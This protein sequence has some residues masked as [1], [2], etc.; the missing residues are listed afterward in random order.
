MHIK[1]VLDHGYVRLVDT[2]GS[3]LTPVNAARVSYDKEST[4][5]TEKDERLL[6][7]LVNAG[8]Q[9]PF[10]HAVLQFEV[11]APLMVAR[12]WFKYRIGST[13]SEDSG[14]VLG[15][16]YN[17]GDDGSEDPLQARNESSRRYVTEEP[18]FYK[19]SAELW[20]TSPENKK[21][22]SGGLYQELTGDET[23]ATMA[24]NALHELITKGVQAYDKAREMGICA[25]QARLFLPAYAMYVRWYWTA[26]LQSVAHFL[27]QR[28]EH[29]AQ[30]EIQQY[31]RAVYELTKPCFPVAMSHFIKGV[32]NEGGTIS[33]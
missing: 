7:F 11:Y 5:L 29:D 20:R 22:G 33:E 13:H 4:E 9:S 28:L 23:G 21:Q 19:P 8:H 2:L 24:T 1:H 32:S 12:Q 31:A 10:R 30:W 3:D 15:L 26:S 27:A 6:R 14:E 18:V 17:N 16:S 25:E